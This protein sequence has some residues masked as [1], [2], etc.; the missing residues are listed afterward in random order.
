MKG[1]GKFVVGAVIIVA[2]VA[3]LA[4][5]GFNES[6]AYY[7]TVDE[8]MAMKD[9]AHNVRLKVAG[10]VVKGSIE[11]QGRMVRFRIEQKGIVVPVNYVGD[12]TLPDTFVDGVQA[13]VEGKYDRSGVFQADKIQAKCASKYQAKQKGATPQSKT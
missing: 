13:V 7:K 6:K 1:K 12:E 5:S 8:L 10:D 3:W 2:A 4:F 11:R 9:Q